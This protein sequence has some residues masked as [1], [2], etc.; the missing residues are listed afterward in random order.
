MTAIKHQS[1]ILVCL[2]ALL[3]T[4]SVPP[5]T[6]QNYKYDAQWQTPKVMYT[7]KRSNVRTGPGTSYGK[8]GLLEVGEQV[9]VSAKTGNWFKLEP[10]AEQEERFVYAPLLTTERPELGTGSTKSASASS[11]LTVKTI[12]YS[13][14]DRYHGQ[15]RNGKRHGRGVFTWASGGRYEGEW[16]N[17]TPNGRGTKTWASDNRYEGDFRDGKAHGRG[18][19]TW[20]RWRAATRATSSTTSGT[21]RGIYTWA[22]GEQ[23]RRRVSR[24][25]F[26]RPRN[27]HAARWR[28]LRR[29]LPR[30]QTERSRGLHVAQWRPLRRRVS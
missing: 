2:A 13:N 9:L 20:P 30:Q 25:I 16:H 14:G 6:A 12:T 18:V 1:R 11:G 8:V 7:T 21:G 26:T 10:K 23:L 24:R 15:I 19:F 29:R 4:M 27:S 22:N 3:V 5:A 17:G 28:P